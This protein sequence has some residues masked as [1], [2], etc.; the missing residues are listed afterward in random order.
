MYKILTIFF[1]VF[2]FNPVQGKEII[3][4]PKIIDGDTI[5]IG[6]NKIRLEGIDSPEIQ[7]KCNKEYL[8]VSFIINFSLKKNYP[9]GVDSKKAL[10]SKIDKSEIKCSIL[11]KDKYKRY[12]ATCFK[13]SL[14]LNKWMVKNG[15][16]VAY[17]RYSKKYVNDE[18]HAKDNKLG[19]WK[20]TFL[21]PEKWRKLN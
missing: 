3:G 6:Q 1:C 2:V 15:Q 12:L 20:G 5:H 9:C 18:K 10:S 19:I 4:I 16:A 13:G 8:Q 7:Q 21:K 14:N 11:S 17:T